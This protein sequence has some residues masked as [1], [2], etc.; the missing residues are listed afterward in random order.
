MKNLKQMFGNWALVTGASS[1]IGKEFAR[2]IAASGM[3]VVLVARRRARLEELATELSS[4]HSVEVMIIDQDLSEENAAELITHKTSGIDIG[5]VI[6]NA[7]DGAMGGFLKHKAEEFG[8]AIKL[9]VLTPVK[10]I[11]SLLDRMHSNKNKGGLILVS[12]AVSVSGVPFIGDY[13]A[14]KAYQLNLGQALHHELLGIGIN[15]SVLMPGPTKTEVYTRDDIDF[16]KLPMPPMSTKRVV[17]SALKGVVKNQA[18]VIPGFIN[19]L[20]DF[21]ARRLMSRNMTSKMYGML[22]KG[23]I[24]PKYRYQ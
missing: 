18:V 4:N 19:N 7:G 10:L 9:N 16:S 17:R 5:L 1:G 23:L 6:S 3:N 15:V 12:S 20:M 21:L 2:Q 8:Q 24:A 13:S 22:M 14:S 11:H